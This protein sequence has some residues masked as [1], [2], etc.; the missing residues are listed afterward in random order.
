[1]KALKFYATWCAPCKGLTMIIEGANDRLPIPVED[2]NIEENIELA[3][4]YGIR[5]VP[6]MVV[7]DDEGNEI[8]REAGMLTEE[9]LLQFLGE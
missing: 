3:A 8:R 5:S 4:K 1:M 9:K 7:V 2:I 6:V